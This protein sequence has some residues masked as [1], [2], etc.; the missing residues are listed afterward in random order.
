MKA[1]RIKRAEFGPNTSAEKL[2]YGLGEAITQAKID[3]K[4]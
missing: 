3:E 4:Q 2:F 1:S